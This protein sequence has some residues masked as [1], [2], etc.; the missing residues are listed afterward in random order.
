MKLYICSVK[1]L[2]GLPA[3][4]IEA[5][6]DFLGFFRRMVKYLQNDLGRLLSKIYLFTIY[7]LYSPNFYVIS[8]L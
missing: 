3:V 5:I 4:I 7:G 8:T 6:P 1:L 2:V